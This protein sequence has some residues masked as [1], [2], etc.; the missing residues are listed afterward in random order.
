LKPAGNKIFYEKLLAPLINR[1][2]DSSTTQLIKGLTGLTPGDFKTVKDRF[3]FRKDITHKDLVMALA[4]ESRLK[5]SH[6][7]LKNIGFVA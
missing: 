1:P 5:A 7:G 4:D 6:A 2:I 3:A